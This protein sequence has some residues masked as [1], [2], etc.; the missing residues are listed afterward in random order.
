MRAFDL[1]FEVCSSNYFSSPDSFFKRADDGRSFD[2][3]QMAEHWPKSSLFLNSSIRQEIRRACD[4][5][6]MVE[7][8]AL[9]AGNYDYV[10]FSDFDSAL[11]LS[12]NDSDTL[13]LVSPGLL[14]I[15]N[16]CRLDFPNHAAYC[17]FETRLKQAAQTDLQT[18]IAS[19]GEFWWA[20]DIDLLKKC[21]TVGIC[22]FFAVYDDH[23]VRTKVFQN[24]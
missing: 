3:Y 22:S 23:S 10:Y 20:T 5:R 15:N 21:E 9:S 13:S 17:L 16:D 6:D 7:S 4:F 14:R 12:S 24:L 11:E 1:V 2:F 19:I 8:V 18:E